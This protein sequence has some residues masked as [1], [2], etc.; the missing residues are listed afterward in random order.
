MAEKTAKKQPDKLSRK[1]I[2]DN[3]R[4]FFRRWLILSII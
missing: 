3:L 2:R 4:I 1:V